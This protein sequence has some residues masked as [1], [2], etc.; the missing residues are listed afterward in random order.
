MG[1]TT[2]SIWRDTREHIREWDL[3]NVT[4]VRNHS[5]KDVLWSP[6][7]WKC[8]ERPMTTLTSR[9]DLRCMCVRT[10]GTR[11]PSRRCT[12][13]TSRS[14]TPSVPPSPSSTTRGIS[15][16][17]T[18]T[19]C[20]DIWSNKCNCQQSESCDNCP[21]ISLFYDIMDKKHLPILLQSSVLFLCYLD[22]AFSI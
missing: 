21:K 2:H 8:M 11:P 9:E 17:T 1:S 10:A 7:V 16:S 12:T 22:P 14:S 6:T 15:S 18:R 13:S 3:T 5:P 20:Q 19:L 4:I